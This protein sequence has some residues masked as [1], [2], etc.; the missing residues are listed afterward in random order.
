MS[1]AARPATTDRGVFVALGRWV[2][3]HKWRV[4][5]GYIVTL[6][7]AGGVGSQL[8]SA[9]QTAGYDD[10]NSESAAAFSFA[11]EEFGI[12]DPSIAMAVTAPGDIDDPATI[13]SATALVEAI[14][15][16]PGVTSVVSY[17]TSGQPAALRGSDNRTGQMLVYTEGLI[18]DDQMTLSN[19]LL[20]KYG[21][22][23]SGGGFDGLE[24]HIGGFA[25][26]S[27]SITRHVTED[28]ARAE[29]IA[30]PLSMILLVIVFGSVVA[31]GLPFTVALGSIVGSFFV[32]WLVTLTTDVSVFALN[33]ITG[34]GLGLGI[35]YALLIVN[36][37]REERSRGLSVDDAVVKTVTTA[38]RTVTVSG[39]TVAVVLSSLIFFPQYFLKSFGYAGIAVTLLA[40]IT[41]VTALPALLAILG[42]RVDKWKVR[43]GDLSPKDVGMWSN[44]ARFV[45]KR[46]VPVLVAT[47]I[48]LA[49]IAAPGLSVSF[50]QTDARVLPADDP[51]AVA[52]AML[53]DLFPGQESTPVEI[54]LPG[55]AA[56]EAGVEAYGA[57]LSQL[58]DVVRVSTPQSVFVDG[59][60]VAPNPDPSA[61]LTDDHARVS[62]ISDLPALTNPAREQVATI[63]GVAAPVD[64]LV[65]G[66]AAQFAD[67]QTAYAEK[68]R[69]ALAW[70]AVATLIILFL[71][72]GSILLPV[73][74][75]L[76]NVLSLAAALGAVVWI[77]QDGN[78]GWLVGDFTVTGGIDTSMAIMIAVVT[79]AL[80]MDYEVFLLSRIK[81][82]HDAGRETTE[83]VALGLQRSGRIITAAAV[84]LAVVF[85][86]FVSSGITSIKQLGFGIAFAILLDATVVRGLLVPSLMRIAGRWNWWAPAPLA[87]FQAKYGLS[88]S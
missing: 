62:L 40:V 57:E 45:M 58:D 78:L 39:I 27:E 67:A 84:L 81:E 68:G 6:I 72:T 31:A 85:A 32:V 2:A 75:V 3:R 82:E 46:P 22:T 83:A 26:V 63:R 8:F 49:T 38:G 21:T 18:V 43:R 7:V 80:S 9:L 15:A 87:R 51:A 77:F 23:S 4:L 19:E 17:W 55:A 50:T 59:A 42:P 1:H 88:E 71:Y 66:S 41:S 36:R 10:P 52:S 48:A 24:V 61:F 11:E 29:S 13:A 20:E 79:F 76:L 53:T 35:D 28:L 44:V 16:E 56:D 86:S 73:K 64:A 47:L 37:F 33:L 14:S 70:I 54:M 74:A 65:G 12:V 69:W 25:A 34:L 30:I 60:V 5:A